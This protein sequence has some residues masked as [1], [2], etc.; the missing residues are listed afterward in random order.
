MD[1]ALGSYV[2]EGP[3]SI[4]HI[5]RS[6]GIYAILRHRGSDVDLLDISESRDLRNALEG[7]QRLPAWQR[8]KRAVVTIFVHYMPVVLHARRREIV[9]EILDEFEPDLVA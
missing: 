8:D 5:G 3:K 6:A 1:I 2:F 4:K 7:H 9:R